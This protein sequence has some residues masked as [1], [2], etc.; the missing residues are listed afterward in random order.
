MPQVSVVVPLYNKA[1]Y[2][3]R[4]LESVAAQTLTDFEVIVVD[5][6]S[7]DGGADIVATVSDSRFKLVRQ[8]NAGPG[9]ARNHG[10]REASAPYVA[11]V[12]A[13]DIWLPDFLR[14]ARAL[15]ER[16]PAAAAVSCGWFEYPGGAS[17]REWWKAHGI[18]EGLFAISADMSVERLFSM[19][20]Y[21][22]PSTI[23]AKSEAVRRWG[24][25]YEDG[26]L[27][28]E[29]TTLWLRV[30]LNEPFYFHLTPLVKLDVEASQL[31][32]NYRG[33]R[34]VE[35]FLLDPGILRSVCP[36]ALLP[37]LERL[38]KLSACK[39]AAVLGF[40]GE[41]RG[42]RQL[43]RSYVNPR[44]WRTPLFSV[45]LLSSS[46]LVRPIGW[47]ARSLGVERYRRS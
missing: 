26:C 6:G 1:S 15:L 4:T 31:C 8:A 14:Q 29:D 28:G 25:F 32:R 20:G 43:V 44:D 33:A 37:L 17:H 3:L 2:V 19:I 13:D 16:H 40:W 7:T 35:P 11:F 23:L 9:A 22:N 42:A 39:T 18:E 36:Q 38:L 24:G 30:F 46:P 27:Y 47:L 21:M 12:D 5:D 45:A 10:L 41:W 34:P